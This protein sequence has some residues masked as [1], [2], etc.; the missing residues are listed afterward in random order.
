MTLSTLQAAFDSP[1]P[2][3][4]LFVVC[5]RL[6]ARLSELGF[7]ERAKESGIDVKAEPYLRNEIPEGEYVYALKDGQMVA[8]FILQGILEKKARVPE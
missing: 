2:K 6:Y 3:F 1:K 7:I 8:T 4:D 5:F